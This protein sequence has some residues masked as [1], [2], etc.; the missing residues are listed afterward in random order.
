[1]YT[2]Y[3]KK[4]NQS[5][6]GKKAA[7]KYRQSEKRKKAYKRYA[8]SEKGKKTAK[9]S[10]YIRTYGITQEDYDQLFEKQNGRCAI[11]GEFETS[12]VYGKIRTLSVD[13][14]HE[15][16]KVRGLLCHKCNTML[17]SSK[18]NIHILEKAILYMQEIR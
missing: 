14:N 3:M 11:C 13:H 17:G 12:K 9:K 4:Y 1:M 15:T 16:G 10:A 7:K 6:R 5:E 8:Q 2:E 18:D